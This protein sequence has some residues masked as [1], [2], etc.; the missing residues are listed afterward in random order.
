M[1]ATKGGKMKADKKGFALRDR[2]VVSF[3]RAAKIKQIFQ[4]ID[5]QK[6]KN[7]PPQRTQTG[8][9]DPKKV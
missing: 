9:R 7:K 5:A 3:L 2:L 6:H 4:K 8:P 1:Y